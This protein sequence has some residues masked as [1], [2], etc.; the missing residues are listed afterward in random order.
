MSCS[1]REREVW[2]VDGRGE[3]RGTGIGC[4]GQFGSSSGDNN[5]RS[6]YE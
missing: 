4:G 2:M 6:F 3:G 1:R 5:K